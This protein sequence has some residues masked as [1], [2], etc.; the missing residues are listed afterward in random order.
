MADPVTLTGLSIA[1]TAASGG[2]SA[3]G[4][5]QAGQA[6]N[7]MYQ[8]RAGVAQINSQIATENADYATKVGEVSAQTEGMKTRGAVGAL[9]TRASA[10]GIDVNTGSKSQVVESAEMV[11]EQNAAVA[12]A[13]AAKRAYGYHVEAMNDT[14]QGQLY[15]TAGAQEERAGDIKA[16]GTLIGTATSV[17]T[18]W[19]GASSAGIGSS[20]GDGGTDPW[21]GMR[22]VS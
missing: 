17:A 18:K 15:R 20:G 12:R 1:G 14:A 2:I 7:Q 21:A 6:A 10:S 16:A 3:I 11:G 9:R 5:V 13:D 22:E 4:Q 19:L 8:Y